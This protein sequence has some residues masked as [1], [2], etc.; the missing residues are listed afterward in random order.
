[1][2]P[3]S[4]APHPC[5]YWT[6][7]LTPSRIQRHLYFFPPMGLLF[8]AMFH[9]LPRITSR[10]HLSMRHACYRTIRHCVHFGRKKQRRYRHLQHLI[11]L[12]LWYCVLSPLILSASLHFNSS[13]AINLR[14]G[15][16]KISLQL[17]LPF[18]LGHLAR[19]LI[20]KW[21]DQ[22]KKLIKIIDQSSILLYSFKFEMR[23]GTPTKAVQ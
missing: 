15:I 10:L 11:F 6:L 7:V 12:Y 4:A 3:N 22:H 5:G 23:Q 1:M 14:D 17:L 8:N 2:A 9:F 13:H 21:I 16:T 20:R 18:I 19:L